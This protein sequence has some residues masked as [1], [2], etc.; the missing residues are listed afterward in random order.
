MLELTLFVPYKDSE[1]QV[2]PSLKPGDQGPCSVE[3]PKIIG[4]NPTNIPTSMKLKDISEMMITKNYIRP[5]IP[6]FKDARKLWYH[7]ARRITRRRPKLKKLLEGKVTDSKT[8]SND[9]F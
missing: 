6:H 5:S 8:N 3:S 7:K 2:T 1:V 4:K 9:S